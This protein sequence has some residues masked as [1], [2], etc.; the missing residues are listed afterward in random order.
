[1]A[2]T[3]RLAPILATALL[4]LCLNAGLLSG[5]ETAKVREQVE[6]LGM[7][8][9]DFRI[10]ASLAET[11]QLSVR[12]LT[13]ELHPVKN[14]RILASEKDL[15]AEHILWCIR[16]LRYLTG[17]KDFCGKT[18]HTFGNSELE[19]D[20]KYWLYFRHKTCISF[21]AMWPSRGS[22]YIAPEDAQNEIIK[23]WKDWFEKDGLSFDYRPLHNPKP[24]DW[25]W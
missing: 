3:N 18:A 11:P 9:D 4:M 21:F 5:Q 17:G 24:E 22:E 20:R 6:R 2:G 12:V 19:R 16:A 23:K 7:G 1:M 25:A 10:V 13:D 8:D 15:G 14:V